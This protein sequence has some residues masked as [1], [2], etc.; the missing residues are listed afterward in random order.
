MRQRG[1]SEGGKGEVSDGNG[2]Q[3]KARG[4]LGDEGLTMLR[5]TT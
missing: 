1:E 5:L 3:R 2:G 4:D